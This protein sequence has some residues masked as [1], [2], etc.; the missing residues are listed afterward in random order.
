MFAG[1]EANGNTFMFVLLL[2]ACHPKI[3]KELQQ[4][5]DEV[6]VLQK[7]SDDLGSYTNYEQHF[8]TLAHGIVGA[9]INESLRLFTVLP[10]IPK[11]VPQASLPVA[12]KLSDGQSHT[13]PSGT[14]I[15]INTSASH[16]HPEY[17]PSRLPKREQMRSSTPV[18][19]F[20]PELWLRGSKQ[21]GKDGFLKPKTG[22]FI[23]FSDGIRGCMGKKFAIVE[24]VA[25][26]ARFFNESSVELAVEGTNEPGVGMGR[27]E[28][29]QQARTSAE[30]KMYEGARFKTSMRLA[31]TI[32]LS[33]VKRGEE[34]YRII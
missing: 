24:L 2:L 23:P 15:L 16:R 11:C 7:D 10:F 8:D 14:L 22:T 12:I 30:L 33:F 9:V 19:D 25:L 21:H 17:W 26:V 1:H 5:L 20:N 32:P 28:A 18:T 13:I 29:W 31:T 27:K 3:Q 4:S 6:L 34:Q